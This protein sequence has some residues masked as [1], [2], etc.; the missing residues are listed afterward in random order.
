M[1]VIDLQATLMTKEKGGFLRDPKLVADLQK[2]FG[3]KDSVYRAEEQIIS[4]FR[5]F[6]VKAVIFSG[7][8]K[9]LGWND[10]EEIRGWHSYIGALKARYPDVIV[11]GWPA[12]DP[13]TGYKGLKEL[14]RCITELKLFGIA[15][16]GALAGVPVN[17]K[18][19]YPFYDMCN[20]LK[21]PVKLWVGHLAM[22]GKGVHLYYEN[23][24]PHVD[25]V[26]AE[27][28]DLTIICAHCPWPFHNEMTSVLINK[29]NVYN[30]VHGTSPKYFPAEFKREINT[31]IQDKVMFGTDYP[32]FSY[33]RLLEDWEA[34]N[35]KPAVLQKVYHQNAARV[36][37][38][39]S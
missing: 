19:W 29:P 6:A 28:P 1:G 7:T 8:W 9:A 13:T 21:V 14:E 22:G 36:L 37:G 25:D 18:L 35:F 4:D 16:C 39:N 11:G 20:E 32:L 17:D 27:F 12:L 38:I 24:I 31:R 30:E 33:E 26:A 23:P 2:Y 5:A 10:F 34:E 3:S 15:A